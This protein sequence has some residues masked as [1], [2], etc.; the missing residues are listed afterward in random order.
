MVLVPILLVLV[1][2]VL[3]RQVETH[4]VLAT[5]VFVG[6]GVS[7]GELECCSDRGRIQKICFILSPA[8][9]SFSHLLQ[10]LSKLLFALLLIFSAALS[11]LLVD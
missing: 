3:D 9:N 7:V 6:G 8:G 1:V 4:V 11:D 2:Q 10:F 5:G